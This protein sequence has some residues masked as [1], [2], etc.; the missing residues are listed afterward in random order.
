MQEWEFSV[1]YSTFSDGCF[2][3]S[4]SE[5]TNTGHERKALRE[6]GKRKI[7]E[8]SWCVRVCSGQGMHCG[9]CFQFH[10]SRVD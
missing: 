6:K 8:F 3:S 1:H 2:V 5:Y 7:K 9:L 4:G 10:S